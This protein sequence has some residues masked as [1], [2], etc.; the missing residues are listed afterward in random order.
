MPELTDA[1]RALLRS[2]AVAHLATINED[3]TPHVAPLWIDA[4]DEGFV[5][6]N[7][8]VGR[9]KDRNVRRDPRVA[10]SVTPADDPY[11]WLSIN[12]TVVGFVDEPEALGHIGALADRYTGEGWTP[13]EGQRR[14]IYRILPERIVRS[15]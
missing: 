12:G 11:S 15:S 2:R 5:L 9:V 3:G 13:V 14:V 6:V 4:D 7:T 10:V 8:A 1:D